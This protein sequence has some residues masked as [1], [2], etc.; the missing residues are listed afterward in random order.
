MEPSRDSHGPQGQEDQLFDKGASHTNSQLGKYI[1]KSSRGLIGDLW[2]HK[3][4]FALLP[5]NLLRNQQ[6][7]ENMMQHQNENMFNYLDLILIIGL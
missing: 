4:C 5:I 1:N 3:C 2:I 7:A 6:N